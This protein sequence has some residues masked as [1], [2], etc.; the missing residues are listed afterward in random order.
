MIA[1]MLIVAKE[2]GIRG[3]YK[4]IW[5]NLRRP[6]CMPKDFDVNVMFK[7][8]TGHLLEMGGL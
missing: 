4:M 2:A 3:K 8:E 5:V 7:V 1:G 6:L